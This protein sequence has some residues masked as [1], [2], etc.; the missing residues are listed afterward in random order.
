MAQPPLRV[1]AVG[2][3]KYP[4]IDAQGR[5]VVSASRGRFVGRDLSGA[6]VPEGELVPHHHD[7]V[8]AVRQGDLELVPEGEPATPRVVVPGVPAARV[9]E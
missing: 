6:I 7:Y 9:K 5:M 4:R 3:R 1:R 2:D 8:I